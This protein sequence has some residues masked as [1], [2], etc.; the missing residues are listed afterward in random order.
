MFDKNYP[1]FCA[2]I[3]MHMELKE[4][5]R[6]RAGLCDAVERVEA[7]FG[8]KTRNLIKLLEKPTDADSN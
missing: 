5:S 1:M 8:K 3:N 4:L 6:T 2:L 7:K